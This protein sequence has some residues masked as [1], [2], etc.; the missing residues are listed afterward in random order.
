MITLLKQGQYKLIKTKHQTKVLY[1][2]EDM[3][4]WVVF[5]G[6]IQILVTS[7]NLHKSDCLLSTGRYRLYEVA[8]EPQLS[9][10]QHLELEAGNN[11]WQSYLLLTGLPDNDKKRS[12]IIPTAEIITDNPLFYN[13]TETEGI[14]VDAV[15]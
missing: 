13:N 7:H 1:L 8:D 5:D 4:A 12:R 10:Q 15:K 9:D 14:K 2:D 6:A 3:Y 11:I